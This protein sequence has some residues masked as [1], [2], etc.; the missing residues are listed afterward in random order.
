MSDSL[1]I[2]NQPIRGRACGACQA[3]CVQIGVA[4]IDKPANTRCGHQFSKG[5]RVYAHRPRSCRFWS[6][7]WLFD[8]DAA[9]LRRPDLSG[10]IVDPNP[11]SF[12]AGGVEQLAM[13]VWIDPA[14]PLSHRAPEL[15]DY[16]T[17]V[18]AKHR[19]PAM[20]RQTPKDAMLLIAPGINSTGE[21]VERYLDDTPPL[22]RETFAAR[23]AEVRGQ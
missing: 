1:V 8:P 9:G 2:Y 20:V 6:C 3:C 18:A 13:V 22:D 19:M 14:R 4:E 16:L 21:W 23:L 11:E 15:R 7:R 12:I 10:Y 5:C 17:V